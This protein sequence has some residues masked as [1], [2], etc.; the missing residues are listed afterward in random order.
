M[1]RPSST[2]G[3]GRRRSVW[4]HV[5]HLLA[6]LHIANVALIVAARGGD[7]LRDREERHDRY[8]DGRLED[9]GGHDFFRLRV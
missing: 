1:R 9:T 7:S 4:T 3:H 5:E 2:S 8:E 6:A